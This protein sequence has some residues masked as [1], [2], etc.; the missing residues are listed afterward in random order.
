MMKP[1]A[2]SIGLGKIIDYDWI[3][4]QQVTDEFGALLGI[5]PSCIK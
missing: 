5:P 4:K 3:A 1:L 2:T